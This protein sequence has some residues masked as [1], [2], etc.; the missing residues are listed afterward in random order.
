MRNLKHYIASL[1]ILG[2]LSSCESLKIPKGPNCRNLTDSVF[3]IN[4]SLPD[5]NPDKEYELPFIKTR[6]YYS[7]PPEYYEKLYN[8]TLDLMEEVEQL[9]R[10]CNVYNSN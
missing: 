4:T 7:V 6:G 1:L 8:F 10:E 2:L 9:R 5:G 3:C